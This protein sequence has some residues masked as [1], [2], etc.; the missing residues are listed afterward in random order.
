[1]GQAKSA[2]RIIGLDGVR[3][4]ACLWVFFSHIY[5]ID[6]GWYEGH[7][8]TGRAW[9]HHGFMGV[10]IFFVLSG[11][12]LSQPFWR[13]H[14]SHGGPQQS[15]NLRSYTRRRVARII[16]G[17]MLALVLPAVINGI[18]TQ[19]FVI[20]SVAMSTI[21]VNQLLPITYQPDWNRPL[22]S[23]SVE[24]AFYLMLPLCWWLVLRFRSLAGAWG[25]IVGLMAL[26]AVGHWIFLG[27]APAIEAA[28]GDLTVFN[29]SKQSTLFPAPVAFTHF[30]FGVLAADLHLRLPYSEAYTRIY[31]GLS[32]LLLALILALPPILGVDGIPALHHIKYAWPTYPFLVAALLFTLPRSNLVGRLVDNGFMRLTARWS[33]GI[34]IWQYPVLLWMGGLWVGRLG[35]R[36]LEVAVAGVTAL[37]GCYLIAG[38]SYRWVELPFIKRFR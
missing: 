2:G 20:K 9:M 7:G 18:I 8:F 33:F 11:F 31:D 30:L 35:S 24:M 38:V 32:L 13:R 4:L 19:P 17:Y 29:A 16:P 37:A 25:T 21:F 26:I 6:E 5:L 15:P 3:A 23:I 34:Y 14:A 22:W 36:P 12:L 28:V 1:M 10:A 27:Y